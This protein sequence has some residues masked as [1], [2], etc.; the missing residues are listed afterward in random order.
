M[1]GELI[2]ITS[3]TMSQFQQRMLNGVPVV[4]RMEY[5][6][7]QF[8][9]LF[10]KRLADGLASAYGEKLLS[11]EQVA[12]INARIQAHWPEMLAQ[13]QE[14]ILPTMTLE[15][16]FIHN[17]LN[18]KPSQIN[19]AEERYRFAT[20]YAHLTRN[21]FTFLDLAAMNVKRVA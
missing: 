5:T 3:V 15:R 8:V 13:L 2:A 21:R 19:M 20:S 1:H 7:E 18:T 6:V 11:A 14:V 16:A 17:G 9:R 4:K 12:S 10:G